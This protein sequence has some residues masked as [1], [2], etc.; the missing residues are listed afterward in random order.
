VLERALRRGSAATLAFALVL[1]V[2]AVATRT[3]ALLVAAPIAWR[4]AQ[5]GRIVAS[6]RGWMP[7]LALTAALLGLTLLAGSRAS[8]GGDSI[9]YLWGMFHRQVW[10]FDYFSPWLRWIPLAALV[11]ASVTVWRVLTGRPLVIYWLAIVASHHLAYAAF[12]DY[13]YR[14]TLVPRLA[15]AALAGTALALLADGRLT[16][17]GAADGRLARWVALTPGAAGGLPETGPPR[18]ARPAGG[19]TVSLALRAAIGLGLVVPLALGVRDIATRYYAD[20]ERFFRAEPRLQTAPY[21]SLE[22]YRGCLFV[23]ESELYRRFPRASHFDLFDEQKRAKLEQ[24][25]DGCILFVYD[26]ENFQA[27]SRSIDGRALKVGRFFRLELLG[28]H[29]DRRAEDY[30]LI[31][32]VTPR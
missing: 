21:L 3:E 8:A 14:H 26:L 29:I 4:L 28:K 13:D 17:R 10:M 32:R 11:A 25:Y 9:R 12:D 15:F 19:R 7:A 16:R 27:S 5:Q 31:F 18:V 20:G 22:P 1:W 23:A 2:T 6:N 24:R 30:A